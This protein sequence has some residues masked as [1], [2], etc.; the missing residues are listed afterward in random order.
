MM[1][2]QPKLPELG[3]IVV[4]VAL[5]AAATVLLILGKID[6]TGATVLYGLVAGIYGVRGAFQAPSP[7]QQETLQQL[8]G[9]V[10]AMLPQAAPNQPESVAVPVEVSKV[11]TNVIP[12]VP[13]P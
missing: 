11:D 2:P 8:L 3:V 7:Q 9:Q 6:F 12:A 13:K 5:I 1:Q 10:L 4:S